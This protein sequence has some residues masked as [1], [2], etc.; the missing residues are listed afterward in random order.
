[1]QK[2][3][4]ERVAAFAYRTGA[5]LSLLLTGGLAAAAVGNDQYGDPLPDGALARLGSVRLRHVGTHQVVFSA[6][7]KSL[8]ST[9]EDHVV[10]RWDISTGKLLDAQPFAL[11]PDDS[12]ASPFLSPDGKTLACLGQKRLYF[13]DAVT[14]KELHRVTRTLQRRPKEKIDAGLGFTADGKQFAVTVANRGEEL[15]VVVP[16][17]GVLLLD[18]AT[19]EPVRIGISDKWDASDVALDPSGKLLAVG[20]WKGVVTPRELPSGRF[21]PAIHVDETPGGLAFSPDSKKLL[22]ITSKEIAFWNPATGVKEGMFSLL[23]GFR[24]QSL[25]FS[26]DGA[27]LAFSS[28]DAILLF[29]AKSM[30]QIRR[31][32]NNNCRY[33]QFSPDGKTLAGFD[34]SAIHLCN[35]ADGKLLHDFAGQD[36]WSVAY[37]A[38]GTSLISESEGMICLWDVATK[39][40]RTTIKTGNIRHESV[41]SSDGQTRFGAAGHGVVKAWNVAD[42]KEIATFLIPDDEKGQ[43]QQYV[44]SLHLSHDGKRLTACL[45]DFSPKNKGENFLV[46]WDV[47]SAKRLDRTTLPAAQSIAFTPQGRQLVYRKGENL[48]LYDIAKKQEC[49][50]GR[51]PWLKPY[52]FSPDGDLLAIPSSDP[53]P[54][55]DQT[56]AFVSVVETATGKVRITLPPGTGGVNAFTPDSRFLLT[57]SFT[58]FRLWELATGKEVLRRSVDG[59]S[60]ASYSATFANAAVVA[61]DGRSAATSLPIGHI[62]VWDLLPS[63]R[64]KGSLSAKDLES[65]WADLAGKDAAEAYYAGGRLLSDPA[66][67]SAFLGEQLRPT[68]DKA[69]ARDSDDGL[70]KGGWTAPTAE[71]R[72]QTRAVWVLEQI[73]SA[74]ARK[75]LERL[76]GGAAAAR[77]TREA[78]SALQRLKTKE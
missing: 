36:T 38:D 21:G 28:D 32:P 60:P 59:L 75:T 47:L 76:A 16:I 58:E 48:V 10:R 55:A 27:Q 15:F 18:V 1:M 8:L 71:E 25:C 73:G 20:E 43:G 9:G 26:V 39:Q 22:I 51:D 74:D 77:Q 49:V 34:R 40:L 5:L 45:R 2:S 17:H 52:T 63:S 4:L 19:G 44:T 56:K 30:K 3:A 6:D 57:T 68:A 70:L 67:T 54:T 7:G 37:S 14:G 13:L 46:V 29:D 69:G 41:F 62:F 72:R 53:S 33:F 35:V 23:P 66:T 65:L 42:G 11:P 78:K 24:C 61:P 64:P 31:L 12:G 50:V